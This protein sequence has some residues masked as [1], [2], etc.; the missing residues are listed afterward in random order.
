MTI[1]L[2]WRRYC[3]LINISYRSKYHSCSQNGLAESNNESWTHIWH[4]NGF[5]SRVSF[6]HIAAIDIPSPGKMLSKRFCVST[7]F[8]LWDTP[9]MLAVSVGK[10]ET[11]MLKRVPSS[12]DSSGEWRM[13]KWA[14]YSLRNT[15]RPKILSRATKARTG[16]HQSAAIWLKTRLEGVEE[17]PVKPQ[18]RPTNMQTY[19][20]LSNRSLPS[21]PQIHTPSR[22][23]P[24][25][26][27][28][29][30]SFPFRRPLSALLLPPLRR[31]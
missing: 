15:K 16:R 3:D 7:F 17:R 20:Q 11:E 1:M 13:N 28:I 2:V 14:D 12:R 10:L 19:P 22:T 8:D 18:I 9:R 5:R 6:Y 23:Q 25:F 29:T 24:S 4:C 27:V 26:V 31:W 30:L 21:Q